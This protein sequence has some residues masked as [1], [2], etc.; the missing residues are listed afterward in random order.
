MGGTSRF[1]DIEDV[2]ASETGLP[3]A[4]PVDPLL[5]TPL[6]IA[7]SCLRTATDDGTGAEGVVMTREEVP[8]LVAEVVSR[9]APRLGA[10]GRRGRLV[11]AFSGATAS[12]PETV[13]QCRLLVLDGYRLRLAFSPAAEQLFGVGRAGGPRRLPAR[14]PRRPIPVAR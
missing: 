11:V 2:M 3:I 1:P 8:G 5:V 14:G 9:L 13:G 10:D 4:L 12:L 7:L 6:G